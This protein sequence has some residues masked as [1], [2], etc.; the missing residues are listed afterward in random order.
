M[1]DESVPR[2]AGDTNGHVAV[3]I[4]ESGA[5]SDSQLSSFRF[6]LSSFAFS[7]EPGRDRTF[8][9]RVKSPLLYH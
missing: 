8:D 5:R 9:R 1:K 2:S 4:P 6:H 3:L 7:G